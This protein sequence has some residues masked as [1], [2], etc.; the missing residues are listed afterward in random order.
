MWNEVRHHL[1]GEPGPALVRFVNKHDYD[2]VI[3]GSRGLN[4]FQSMVLGSV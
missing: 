4:P 1:R 3:I 2:C